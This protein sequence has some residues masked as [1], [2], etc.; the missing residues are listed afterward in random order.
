MFGATNRTA[1]INATIESNVTKVRTDLLKLRIEAMAVSRRYCWRCRVQGI[2][3]SDERPVG[4]RGLQLVAQGVGHEP[5]EDFGL[6]T[7]RSDTCV[8]PSLE[9]QGRNSQ[10]PGD[11]GTPEDQVKQC[12]VQDVRRH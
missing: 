4:Q 10:L 5:F 8:D 6:E 12:I 11:Q 3:R 7:G 9:G 1:N 2:V